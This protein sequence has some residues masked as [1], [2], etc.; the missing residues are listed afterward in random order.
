[1]KNNNFKNLLCFLKNLH[2]IIIH[3]ITLW[4]SNVYLFNKVFEF[5]TFEYIY[6]PSFFNFWSYS[7]PEYLVEFLILFK[8][9]T[10]HFPPSLSHVETKPFDIED[11]CL[12]KLTPLCYKSFKKN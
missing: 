7:N 5:Y 12:F 2:H 3:D 1:M 6:C 10:T 9:L 8:K 11:I 4:V